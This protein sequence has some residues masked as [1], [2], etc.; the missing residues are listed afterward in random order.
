MS[1]RGFCKDAYEREM[2]GEGHLTVSWCAGRVNPSEEGV[3]HHW[4]TRKISDMTALSWQEKLCDHVN[5]GGLNT[6]SSHCGIGK[7]QSS[8]V[9]SLRHSAIGKQEL[10]L[11]EILLPLATSVSAEK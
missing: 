9:Q 8:G 1:L 11:E 3:G 6:H 5:R 7:T 4:E 2:F 10:A